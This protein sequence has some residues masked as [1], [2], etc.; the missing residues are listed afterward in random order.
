MVLDA[1]QSK[2]PGDLIFCGDF[3]ARGSLWGNTVLNPQGEA[4]EDALDK[5][6]VTCINNGS[7]T[8]QASRPGDSDSAID[9]TITSLSIAPR[10]KWQTLGKHSNDRYPCTV[11]IK[12]KK[13]AEEAE[14]EESLQI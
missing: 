10:C 11:W 3:N 4:L 14:K 7:M 2:L 6:N 5:S 1:I 8:R 9:L 13:S 12:R